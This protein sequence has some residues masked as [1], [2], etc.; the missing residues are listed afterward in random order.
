MEKKSLVIG[1]LKYEWYQ[2]G[3]GRSLFLVPAFHS[4]IERFAPFIQYLSRLFTVIVPELP[5]ISISN[6][7]QSARHT[8][9]WYAIYLNRLI[10]ALRLRDYVLSGLCLGATIAVRQL[11]IGLLP[12][13]RRLL[14]FETIYRG[15]M[16]HLDRAHT[17]LKKLVFALG[18]TH[19]LSLSLA[20]F[21]LQNETFLHWYFRWIFRREANRD[22]VIKNQIRLTKVMNPQTWLDIV[23]D[24]FQ[25]DLGSE[26][27]SLDVPAILIYNEGDDIIDT[28]GMIAG[29]KKKFPSHELFMISLPSHAPPGPIS[30]QRVQEIIAPIAPV[31][32]RLRVKNRKSRTSLVI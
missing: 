31:F 17:V 8:V 13:P 18:P 29:M 28:Q 19:P 30:E 2:T 26:P 14:L 11:E 12:K 22:V 24:L 3:K 21:I 27:Q 25:V 32:L 20:R 23:S 4:D 6:P 1:G 7:V 15:D 5:G 10:T 9:D 16:I